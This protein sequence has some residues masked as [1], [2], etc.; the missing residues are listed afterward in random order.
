MR[1]EGMAEGMVVGREEGMAEGMAVGMNKAR[2]GQIL[3]L[4]IQKNMGI[5]EISGILDTSP[6]FVQLV[7]AL[8]ELSQSYLDYCEEQGEE[9]NYE[10]FLEEAKKRFDVS[11]ETINTVALGSN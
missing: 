4:R 10:V 8:A 2:I 3:N 5:E 1:A 6:E 7:V 11:A 9:P